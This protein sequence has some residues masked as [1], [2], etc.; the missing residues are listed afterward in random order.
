MRNF[1]FS[2]DNSAIRSSGLVQQLHNILTVLDC[3]EIS[4]LSVL[5]CSFIFLVKIR[6][7]CL[8]PHIY[9][10][11]KIRRYC[12]CLYQGS[13]ALQETL[14]FYITCQ[15]YEI[16]TIKKAGNSYFYLSTLPLLPKSGFC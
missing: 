14:S 1:C 15:I 13:K 10:P 7:L 16:L 4:L 5:V 3:I 9:T 12:P 6:L 11:K 2:S 8:L